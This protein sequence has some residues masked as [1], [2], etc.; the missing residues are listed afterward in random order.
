MT[1][2][3]E[4]KQDPT[5][6]PEEPQ[7]DAELEEGG[8][9]PGW[10]SWILI[11]AAAAIGGYMLGA[12][13]V[14]PAGGMDANKL[15]L[16]KA[17]MQKEVDS[18]KERAQEELRRTMERADQKAEQLAAQ[19]SR[20]MIRRG[21]LRDG[22]EDEL[23]KVK[24]D[25]SKTAERLAK[26][27]AKPEARIEAATKGIQAAREQIDKIQKAYD[28]RK[29]AV[30]KVSKIGTIDQ[31]LDVLKQDL[32]YILLTRFRELTPQAK[33]GQANAQREWQACYQRIARLDPKLGQK[34][35]KSFP[36][37]AGQSPA[38]AATTQTAP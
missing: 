5:P 24:A 28:V 31:V 17:K 21:L 22:L 18:F 14:K 33:A 23:G 8:G 16:E 11:I 15:L 4:P 30:E 13:G 12:Q 1:D 34:L 26:S 38:G 29:V 10:F 20:E 7:I 6:T 37:A 9:L 2:T 27:D 25:L 32:A 35:A 36:A 19:F 3:D